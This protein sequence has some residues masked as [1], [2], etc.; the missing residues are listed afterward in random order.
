MFFFFRSTRY[1]YAA[2]FAIFLLSARGINLSTILVRKVFPGISIKNLNY[3]LLLFIMVANVFIISPPKK[4][5]QRY[6]LYKQY[7]DPFNLVRKSN[8]SD[9]IVFLKSV[10]EVWNNISYYVQNPL[11]YDGKV[12]FVKDLGKRNVELI[13]YYPQKKFYIYEFDQ[14]SKSGKLTRLK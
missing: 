14:K 4:F 10:P 6:E 9:S 5:L 3:L 8:L 11:N 1:Y 2:Y 13:E 12:L 7:R